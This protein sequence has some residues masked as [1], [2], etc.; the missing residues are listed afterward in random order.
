MRK[1]VVLPALVA[2]RLGLSGPTRAAWV[3]KRRPT[4]VYQRGAI[5]PSSEDFGMT[6]DHVYDDPREPRIEPIGVL[7]ERGK[8]LCRVTVP[9]KVPLGFHSP[10]RGQ[11]I[12]DEVETIVPEDMLSVTEV[13]GTGLGYIDEAEMGQEV[14]ELELADDE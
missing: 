1:R 6:A 10:T 13:A 12:G 9:I 5:L 14:D 4:P 2:A 7:D 8:M 11:P 3:P